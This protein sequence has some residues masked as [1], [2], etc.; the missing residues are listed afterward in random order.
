M[1]TIVLGQHV[2]IL[3]GLLGNMRSITLLG[4]VLS[5]YMGL[6]LVG[7]QFMLVELLYSLL[8]RIVFG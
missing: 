6:Q 1:F 3:I 8:F 7:L 2:S 5:G 4:F